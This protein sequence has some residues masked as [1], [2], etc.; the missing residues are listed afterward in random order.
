MLSIR[1]SLLLCRHYFER[2]RTVWLIGDFLASSVS[3]STKWFFLYKSKVVFVSGV[4]GI[5]KIFYTLMHV[6]VHM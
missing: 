3:F 6:W 5:G 4:N 1:S 2:A